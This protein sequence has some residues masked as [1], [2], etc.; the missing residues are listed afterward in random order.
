MQR[1][2]AVEM[3]VPK[4]RTACC[5]RRKEGSAKPSASHMSVDNARRNSSPG[6]E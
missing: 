4:T 2:K 1:D 5:C 3:K 6:A